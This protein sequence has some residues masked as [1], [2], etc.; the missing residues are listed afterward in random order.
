MAR[1]PDSIPPSAEPSA[2][3]TRQVILDVSG[4]VAVG[5]YKPGM[6]YDLPV[7]EADRLVAWKGFRYV[8]DEISHEPTA[9]EAATE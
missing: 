8:A 6:V 2:P 3:L 1:K 7:A 5:S 4:I 9:V